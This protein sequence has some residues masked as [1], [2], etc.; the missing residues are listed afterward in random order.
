M[1]QPLVSL[2]AS[3]LLLLSGCDQLSSEQ[4]KAANDRLL[5]ENLGCIQGVIIDGLSRDGVDLLSLTS[6]AG[7]GIRAMIG[8][9][10]VQATAAASFLGASAR[11]SGE[12][13][14][15]NIPL[16][17]RYNLVV[18]LPG[19]QRVEGLFSIESSLATRSADPSQ[20]EIYKR[21]PTEIVNIV[22]YPV[23]V[24]T[25]DLKFQVTHEG[26]ALSDARV[27]LLSTG[28]NKLDAAN[29]HALV[30]TNMKS[31]PLA[32]ATDK[33]GQ[34]TFKAENLV[35]GATYEYR[36]FPPTGSNSRGFAKGEFT[37][38]L[39]DN[40]SKGL[41]YIV[42]LELNEIQPDLKPISTNSRLAA[43]G[44]SELELIFNRPVELLF[45]TEDDI[46]AVV[47]LHKKA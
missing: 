3:S 15:C 16:D 42:Q 20:L 11:S 38:G 29:N 24:E 43:N 18:D 10:A 44:Y 1:R 36:V 17:E 8:G 47:S 27:Q 33:E 2:I 25:A 14:I 21:V 39:I 41:P 19:F 34:V 6:E 45:D 13:S 40:A 9:T 30:Y 22:V 7:S 23:G 12:Y 28:R 32:L 31:I 35:L 46:K 4:N 26:K 37:L 5:A